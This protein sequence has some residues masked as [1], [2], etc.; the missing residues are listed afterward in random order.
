MQV[1]AILSVLQVGDRSA[2][3]VRFKRLIDMKLC[4]VIVVVLKTMSTAWDGHLA[5]FWVTARALRSGGSCP[6]LMSTDV[7][8]LGCDAAAGGNG[9]V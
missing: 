3:V 9:G 5:H 7:A 6:I 8:Q 1:R 2:G 4:K